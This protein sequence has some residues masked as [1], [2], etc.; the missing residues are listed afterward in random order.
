MLN[1]IFVLIVLGSILAAALTGRM[2]PLTQSALD[3]ARDAVFLA[4]GLIGVMALFLGLM[5]VAQDGG[6]LRIVSRAV[7]PV[8]RFLF[9][10]IPKDHPA[11][12]AMLMNIASNMLG[13]GNAATPFG[14][15]A[16]IEL[17]RLNRSK[18]TATD[19][20]VLFLAVNTSGLAL[21]PTGVIAIRAAEGSQNP[22]GIFVTTWFASGCATVVGILAAVL[23]SRLRRYRVPDGDTAAVPDPVSEQAAVRASVQPEPEI[24]AEPADLRPP[25]GGRWVAGLYFLALIVALIVHVLRS[26]AG[27]TTGELVREVASYWLLPALIAGLVLFGWSRGVKVYESLVEG[28]KEGFQ[29]AVRIIPYLV[30][31]L[32]AVGM[33]R[34]SGALGLLVRVLDPVTGRIGLPAEALPMALIRPLSGSGALGVMAETIQTHGPDSFLGYLVSTFQGSTETTFYVLAVYFGAVGIRRMRHALPACLAADLTGIL[35]AV[36]IVNLLFG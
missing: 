23:L 16:M 1:G 21:L 22:A 2:E 30:A 35:A 11:M 31:I 33:F 27:A 36:L 6:L 7:H 20:M 13:L 18:G 24:A 32:V 12:S 14:I 5:R 10:S 19:A 25:R 29:V 15:K 8:L 28:A 17:D 4:L 3:S 9:P 34:A 26:K